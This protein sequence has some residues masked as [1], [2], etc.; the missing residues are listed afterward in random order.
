MH[1]V[2]IDKRFSCLLGFLRPFASAVPVEK[3]MG[4]G[5]KAKQLGLE[6]FKH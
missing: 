1:H 5:K 2:I 6:R 4:K 3:P